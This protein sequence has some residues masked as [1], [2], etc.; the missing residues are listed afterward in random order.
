MET[1]AVE[2]R[3]GVQWVTLRRPDVLNAMNAR[4]E[5]ELLETLEA[6]AADPSVRV[7]VLRGAGPCFSAGHD[8]KAMGTRARPGSLFAAAMALEKPVVA[9][10][11]GY[12]LGASLQLALACD[13]R[14]A[15]TDARLGFPFA[16]RGVVGATW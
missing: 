2:L 12:A 1:L 10:L 9:S 11:H 5:D 16:K 7:V 3:D 4:M 15:A 14:I 8:A 13:L 6:A